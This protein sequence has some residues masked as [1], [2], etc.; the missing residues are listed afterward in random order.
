MGRLPQRQ[1][2]QFLSAVG[3]VKS[4]DTWH[5]IHRVIPISAR[6]YMR[7]LDYYPS[8]SSVL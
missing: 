8:I 1:G 3:T 4:S 6:I 2:R 5:L 7:M